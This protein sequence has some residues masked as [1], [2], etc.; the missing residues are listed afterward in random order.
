MRILIRNDCN[1]FVFFFFFIADL[2]WTSEPVPEGAAEGGGTAETSRLLP[3]GRHADHGSPH[4][5]DEV[6]GEA[7]ADALQSV[8]DDAE[9]D[10]VAQ[11]GHLRT[12]GATWAGGVLF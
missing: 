1:D 12:R 7:V 11:A 6:R 9:A 5:A 2:Q 10:V 8:D 3:A 4:R